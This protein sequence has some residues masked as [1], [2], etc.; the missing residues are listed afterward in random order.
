MFVWQ[1]F[2][3]TSNAYKPSKTF[4]QFFNFFSFYSRKSIDMPK[5]NYEISRSQLSNDNL[6]IGELDYSILCCFEYFILRIYSSE[7]QL[8]ATEECNASIEHAP[9]NPNFMWR[10]PNRESENRPLQIGYRVEATQTEP[11]LP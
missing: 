6:I 8:K 11:W 2:T 5:K 4:N 10:S 9:L 3:G 7:R 1:I